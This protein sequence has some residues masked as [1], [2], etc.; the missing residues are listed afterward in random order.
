MNKRLVL[1]LLALLPAACV[2]DAVIDLH[3]GAVLQ[4]DESYGSQQ[5]SFFSSREWTASSEVSWITV[6]PNSGP[7][8]EAVVSVTVIWN[9]PSFGP[10]SG[11]VVLRCGEAEK[12]I[13]IEQAQKD[14]MELVSSWMETAKPQGDTLKVEIAHNIPIDGVEVDPSA[15]AWIRPLSTKAMEH[16]QIPFEID[17]NEGFAGR[18][19]KVYV[20]GGGQRIEVTVT[21]PMYALSFS[22]QGKGFLNYLLRNF[23]SN[24]DGIISMGEALQVTELLDIDDSYGV[25]LENLELFRNV[26]AISCGASCYALGQLDLS[27]LHQLRSFTGMAD[28]IDVSGCP[29]L[30]V[31]VT[32]EVSKL[33]L[34]HNPKLRELDV[35]FS[36]SLRLDVRHNPL[37]ERIDWY[38]LANDEVDL[39]GLSRLR[40]VDG[41]E[42]RIKRLLVRDCSALEWLRCAGGRSL[43]VLD[44]R[45]CTN[46]CEI[47]VNE[48]NL[49]SLDLSETPHLQRLNLFFNRIAALDLIACPELDWFY[50]AGNRMETLN[51]QGCRS[52][53]WVECTS[54]S[55]EELDF[56]G[57]PALDSLDCSDCKPLR[58]LKVKGCSRLRYL[59]CSDGPRRLDLSGN[60]ALEE[61]WCQQSLEEIDL[62]HNP[63]LREVNVSGSETITFLDLTQNPLLESVWGLYCPNLEAVY[64]SNA[65]FFSVDPST[66]VYVN[67]ERVF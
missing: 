49:T 58:S 51:V 61:F 67:G 21:Q 13:Q 25:K 22:N 42:S 31:L 60:P 29:E 46:L 47:D 52:L 14:A 10:R 23:D 15:A 45:G 9:E 16:T 18:E 36:D 50:C 43:E 64:L 57:C 48:N 4:F 39:S 19:G 40:H 66:K 56:S 8:G 54:N 38:S 3:S 30:E 24:K 34:S 11:G 37:L 65:A 44:V 33:D 7:V 20:S 63:V 41:H 35:G 55:F 17:C 32:T 2:P 53:R 5:L 26:T 59:H 62:S 28:E 12:R 6:S 27:A 1:L